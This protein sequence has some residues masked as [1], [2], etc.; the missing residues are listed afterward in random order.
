MPSHSAS[1]YVVLGLLDHYGPATPYQLDRAVDGGIGYFWNF[2]RSQLYAE[3]GR[4]AR[5]GLLSEHQEEVGRRRRLFTITAEGRHELHLWLTRTTSRPTEIRDEGLLKLF[6]TREPRGDTPCDRSTL[7]GTIRRLADE[8][9]SAHRAQLAGYQEL[10]G[11]GVIPAGSPQ[12]ATVELG[13]RFERLAIDFWDE[14]GQ[15]PPAA[16]A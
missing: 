15:N 14:I 12:R 9:A 3:A 1:A 5:V 16:S 4:L 2:S 13:L 6:F 10:V 7:Q 8:Q 11:S